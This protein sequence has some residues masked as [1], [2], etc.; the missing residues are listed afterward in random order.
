[1]TDA[2][3]LEDLMYDLD[4][5]MYHLKEAANALRRCKDQDAA[6]LIDSIL[7]E[8]CEEYNNVSAQVDELDR[9]EAYAANRDYER[10]TM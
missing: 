7:V 1:M 10:S 8:K 6:E 3:R 2:E 9:R 4:D 5:A